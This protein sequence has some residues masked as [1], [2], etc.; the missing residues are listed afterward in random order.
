MS[1]NFDWCRYSSFRRPSTKYRR[2]IHLIPHYFSEEEV[3]WGC[4]RWSCSS[5]CD[6][7]PHPSGIEHSMK[8]GEPLTWRE[9]APPDNNG[10]L[11]ILHFWRNLDFSHQ[12]PTRHTRQF[13]FSVYSMLLN[14]SKGFSFANSSVMRVCKRLHVKATPTRKNIRRMKPEWNDFL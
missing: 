10:A 2:W 4:V 3:Q 13:R 9:S 7:E 12:W 6:R 8:I 5:P 14:F 1:E 11:Q